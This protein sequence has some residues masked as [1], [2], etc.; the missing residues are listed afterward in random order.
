MQ[1]QAQ[2]Y[3]AISFNLYREMRYAG[4]VLLMLLNQQIFPEQIDLASEERG[5][6]STSC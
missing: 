1:P 6:I 5:P 3:V 2:L 4:Q